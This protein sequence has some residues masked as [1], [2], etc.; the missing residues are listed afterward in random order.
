MEVL[1]PSYPA[2]V[3]PIECKPYRSASAGSSGREEALV[4]RRR[5]KMRAL[6]VGEA[7]AR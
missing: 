5:P 4:V 2:P 6:R 1:F 7:A 3:V